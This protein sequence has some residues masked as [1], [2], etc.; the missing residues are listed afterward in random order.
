M[1]TTIN[2]FTAD[3]DPTFHPDADENG[4]DTENYRAFNHRGME[5]PSFYTPH[6]TRQP[7]YQAFYSFVENQLIEYVKASLNHELFENA[8][9]LCERLYA[10]VQN[11]DIKHLLAQ[12]YLGEGK[13]YKAYEVLK[14]CQSPKNRYKFA[15]TCIKLGH[16]QDAEKA[17]TGAGLP[18]NFK[19][20]E[21]NTLNLNEQFIPNGA[22]GYYLLG[23]VLEK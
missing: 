4:G 19:R 1:A 15:L 3:A 21:N 7:N 18:N 22:S 10:Q 17:L 16:Y 20:T 8:T 5:S 9:F 23:L 14:D 6:P 11:E 2:H 12:C 13:A